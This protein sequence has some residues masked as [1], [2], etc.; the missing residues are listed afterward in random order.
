MKFREKPVEIEAIEFVYTGGGLQ[1]LREFCGD[2]LGY[3]NKARHINAKAEAEIKNGY[4]GII[5]VAV[6]GDWIVKNGSGHF[7]PCDPYEFWKTY[8]PV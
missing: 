3:V 6:E 4:S 1:A 7:Y 5:Y 2:A 8:E